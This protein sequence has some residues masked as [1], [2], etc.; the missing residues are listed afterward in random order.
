LNRFRIDPL[1]LVAFTLS[2][3]LLL[4][5]Q[6]GVISPSGIIEISYSQFVWLF[7]FSVAFFILSTA[8]LVTRIPHYAKWSEGYSGT[9]TRVVKIADEQK[10]Y[11]IRG[12]AGITIRNALI[13]AW[14]F[15]DYD[16]TLSWHVIDISGNDISDVPLSSVNGTAT[17]VIDR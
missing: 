4:V 6:F 2:A 12:S 14:P 3:V 16:P 10:D 11:F 7:W 1:S 9:L 15:G 17:V 13:D 5:V 8:N